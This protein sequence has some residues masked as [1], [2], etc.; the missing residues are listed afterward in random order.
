MNLNNIQAERTSYQKHL[1]ILL[2]EKRNFKQ[3]IDNV[4]SQK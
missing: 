3:Y 4:L 2:D 1:G